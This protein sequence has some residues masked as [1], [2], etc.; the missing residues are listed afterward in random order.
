[1][2]QIPNCKFLIGTIIKEKDPNNEM[3]YVIYDISYSLATGKWYYRYR[4]WDGGYEHYCKSP[5][6]CVENL[7]EVV[8]NEKD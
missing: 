1:M 6:K 2:I 3:E 5:I 8:A 4:Y 7:F